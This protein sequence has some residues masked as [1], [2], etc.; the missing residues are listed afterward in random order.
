MAKAGRSIGR[1]GGGGGFGGGSR[2]FFGGGSRSGGGGSF[3]GG[4]WGRSSSSRSRSSWNWS[5]STGASSRPHR[6][7]GGEAPSAVSWV[8]IIAIL[9]IALFLTY[10]VG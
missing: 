2:S 1:S 7:S 4:S 3:G 8:L 6:G 9:A 5:P 10:G